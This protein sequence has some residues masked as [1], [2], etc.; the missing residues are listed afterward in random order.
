MHSRFRVIL[1]FVLSLS[2]L[3]SSSGLGHADPAGQTAPPT[4]RLLSATITPG[5][6]ESAAL[7]DALSLSGYAAGQAGYY[8]L[9]FRAPVQQAWVDRL[10]ALG[11]TFLDYLPDYAFKVRMT[12]EQAALATAA[13]DVHWV[14]IF[15]PAYKIAPDVSRSANKTQQLYRVR[16]ERGADVAAVTAQIAASG[17]WII[18]GEDNFVVLAADATQ[19]TAVANLLDVAWSEAFRLYEKHNEY[20]AGGIMGANV[21]NASGYNG[22]TQIAAVA[23]T[24]FGTGV[25]ATAHADVP[26]SRIVALQN[27]PG[28]NSGGCYTSISDGIADVDSGHGSHVALSVLGDGGA[29]GEGKGTA[30]AAS[31]VFQ[32]VEN[33]VDFTGTCSLSYADGYYLLGIPDNLLNLYQPAYNAGA[34]VHSNSWGSDAL[35]DYTADSA[36][37][38]SFMWSNPSFL[39]TFSAGNSGTDAN[40][41]GVVDNDSIGSPATAKNV[42]TVGASE[43]DRGGNYN[44]DTALGYT[45]HD[46]YQPGQTCSAMG[47]QNLLG[48][49]GQRWGADFPAAPIAGD[50]TAGNAE[51]MAAF[52]SRGPTDDGR[53]K[54]DVVAPGTWVLS[55]YSDM[56]QQGYGDP[57]NPQNGRYQSDGWGMPMNQRYKY[58]GGTSMSNPLAA[59]GATVVRDFYQKAYSHNAS[60]ALVKASL[61]NTAVDLMDENNDGANDNDFP[62]PNVHE[63]WG[64]VNLIGATSIANYVD[65]SAGVSTVGAV[66]QQFNVGVAGGP[67]KVSLVWTD[68]PSTETAALNLVND[69]D[70]LVTAPGGATYRGNVF[71]GGWSQSS[72]SADRTNNVENVYIQSA[73]AG[74]WSV[75]VSGFNVPNG[76]QPYALVVT[77]AIGVAPTATPTNT[78][79]PLT[80]TPTATN[81]PVSPTATPTPTSTAIPPTVTPT[82]TA[83]AGS[84]NLLY[85]SSTTDGNVGF[86]FSDEDIVRFDPSTN[87]WTLFF[88]GSDVGL[89]ASS[90]HDIDAFHINADGSILLSLVGAASI[91]NL[92]TIDDSDIVRFVPTTLGANTTGV[93]QWYFDG[94]DVG[95]TTNAEDIDAIGLLA[96]GRLL[97]SVLGSASVPGV[98]AADEDLLAFAPTA[99]GAATSGVW[100]LYF[101]G[102]DVGLTNFS[103][104]VGGVW[105]NTTTGDIYLATSGLFSV[106]GASGD[107]ADVFVCHPTSVG[108]NTACAFGPGLYFDGSTKSFGGEVIDDISLTSASFQGNGRFDANAVNDP[109]DEQ[110]TFD[111]VDDTLQPSDDAEIIQFYLPILSR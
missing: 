1:T 64:R 19:L 26:A 82:P 48:T 18:R 50:S 91:P 107:A 25:A 83:P 70:L 23:D 12:P 5:G 46:A 49:Y 73:A 20:G 75:Q 39:V 78:P 4:I 76:P 28:G 100:S 58:F 110:S 32:A 17:A 54:P 40:T 77:G 41:N 51:Q 2:L 14:G 111:D 97:I 80:A 38:D 24:G 103:E 21:V 89:G 95:L 108:A 37:S 3:L 60:A 22:S 66:T 74:M 43:N 35:G 72:G 94:S 67:F 98:S 45:S 63:G 61:I 81:T 15:Q 30:P 44:C 59:G 33:Y 90:N 87:A 29:S 109:A 47:G 9:Q 79:V 10:A 11:I 88:D 85:L 52:S 105:A 7:P 8:I 69:L 68:Y 42:L 65:N 92:G 104:N 102:S 93:Y 6:L 71:S 101:D 57:I 36:S 99:L 62:I 56:H 53:I 96:D 13:A 27:F 31:L 34:R 16:I 55:G 84:A 86:V 106:S